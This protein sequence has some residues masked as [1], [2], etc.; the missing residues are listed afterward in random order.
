MTGDLA[1][2]AEDGLITI[3]GREK[4]MINV[5]GNKVFPEEVEHVLNAHPSVKMSRVFGGK[6]PLLGE[7]VQAEIVPEGE[8]PEVEELI[9]FCRERLSTYKVPQRIQWVEEIAFTA[10]GKIVRSG[11]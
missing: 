3:R 8:V 4:S 7:V 9:G 2:K 10:T 11:R 5:S 1:T 6:H